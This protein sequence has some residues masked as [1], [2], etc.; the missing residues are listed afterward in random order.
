M[1]PKQM[2]SL[3]IGSLLLLIFLSSC[4]SSDPLMIDP[5]TSEPP[6]QELV[7]LAENILPKPNTKEDTA[8]QK[9]IDSSVYQGTV[10]DDNKF[11]VDINLKPVYFTYTEEM[12]IERKKLDGNQMT[13]EQSQ[14][15]CQ[16][17][18]NNRF[19]EQY[20]EDADDIYSF[21]HNGSSC[22]TVYTSED[23]IERYAKCRQ[24]KSVTSGDHH[25]EP[26][27]PYEGEII[28]PVVTGI[29]PSLGE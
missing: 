16:Q 23:D 14:A 25:I 20:V 12:I 9:K 24:V 27:H 13:Y 10:Y 19:V 7:E 22:I 1:K 5:L 29:E 3:L 21:P 11:L 4:Q 15:L 2:L 8:W 28:V 17:V 26:Y 18:Y 6:K